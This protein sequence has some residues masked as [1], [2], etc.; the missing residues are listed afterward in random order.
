MGK[1]IGPS[2]YENDIADVIT[3]IINVFVEQR[4]EGESFLSTYNRIGMA[5]F[6]ERVYASQAD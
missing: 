1:I 3:N 4:I 6:K 2:F 5:P